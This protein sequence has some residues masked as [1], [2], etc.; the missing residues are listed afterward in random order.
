QIGTLHWWARHDNPEKYGEIMLNDITRLIE[1]LP[2]THVGIAK[3][4]YHIYRHEFVSVISGPGLRTVK[5]FH[6]ENH[7]W[8][9]NAQATLTSEIY[10]KVLDYFNTAR[11]KFMRLAITNADSA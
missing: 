1:E 10:N 7:R 2:D 8:V 4:I 6:F 9:A 5:W 11:N 3:I